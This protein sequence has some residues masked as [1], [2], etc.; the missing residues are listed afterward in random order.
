M[1]RVVEKVYLGYLLAAPLGATVAAKV[2][3]DGPKDVVLGIL[4]LGG[5]V[6]V[7][8]YAAFIATY[9]VGPK[10]WWRALL[11]IVDGPLLV[12]LAAVTLDGWRILDLTTW[13]FV[14]EAVGIYLGIAVLAWRKHETPAV[15]IMLACIGIVC[16]GAG[17]A[18]F[19]KLA[20]DWR[21]AVMFAASIAQ[22]CVSAYWTADRDRSMR[23]ADA[24]AVVILASMGLFFVAIGLGALLRFV[25]L[26]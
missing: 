16:F 14:S 24:S 13:F 22:A 1:S 3:Y 9:L 25:M 2:T 8:V 10:V 7:A 26:V 23:D 20:G 6:A 19:P 18:L 21:S 11:T 15:A 17:W 4:S 12:A 5:A